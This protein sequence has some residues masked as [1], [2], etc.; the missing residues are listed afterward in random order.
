MTFSWEHTFDVP[1]ER[2]RVFE[3]L[4]D[5]EA[6]RGW[7]AEQVE[8]EPREGGAFRFS[9]RG[10]YA[11]G[12]EGR[13]TAFEPGRRLRLAYPFD[14]IAGEVDLR[15]EEGAEPTG[16]RLHLTHTLERAPAGARA[17]E[18]MEDLWRLY[19]INLWGWVGD[20]SAILLPD[21]ADPS[22]K[23]ELSIFIAA[24]P[25]AVFRA[26]LEPEM[27][28]TVFGAP[29]PVVEPRAGGAY[30]FGWSYEVDGRQVAGG[31]TRILEITPN[32][33]LVT[34]WPDWRG[35]PAMPTQR[36]TWTLTPEGDGTRVTLLHDG[37]TRWTD[38][39]DY[40]GG[41]GHFLSQLKAAAE[42]QSSSS[43]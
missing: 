27:L 16:T 8:I 15:L 5:P 38:I 32:E 37:F 40:P 35:D 41:W 36:V 2:A 17:R 33:R 18:L 3:A 9:G 26:L 6:L 24:P 34:D 25:P 1:A 11:G 30:R 20:R 4:T 21:F 39:G 23:V 13:V 43:S 10:A 7:F 29:T 22:P 28:K 19:V 14:G 42:A 31:P 12:A